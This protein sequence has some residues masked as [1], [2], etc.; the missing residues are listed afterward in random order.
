MMSIIKR[1]GAY[2]LVMVIGF[3]TGSGIYYVVELTD[4]IPLNKSNI[5]NVPLGFYF[6][7]VGMIS[8]VIIGYYLSKE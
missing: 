8:S 1:I 7:I 3:F 5:F 4:Y 2:L 6:G